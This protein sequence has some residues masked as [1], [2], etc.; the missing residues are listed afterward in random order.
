MRSSGGGDGEKRTNKKDQAE[1]EGRER[2]ELAG[3]PVCELNKGFE[4]AEERRDE[5]S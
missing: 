2:I 4:R 5:T 3:S 1:P